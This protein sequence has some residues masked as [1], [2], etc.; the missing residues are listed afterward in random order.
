[1]PAED[2]YVAELTQLRAGLGSG[3]VTVESNGRR[4]TYR[5]VGEIEKAIRHFELLSGVR[6][7]RR[8]RVRLASYEGRR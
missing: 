8:T 1:M 7:P 5:G 3:L 2:Q 4:V 6:K